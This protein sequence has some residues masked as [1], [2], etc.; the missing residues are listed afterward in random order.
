LKAVINRQDQIILIVNKKHNF[1]G[2]VLSVTILSAIFFASIPVSAFSQLNSTDSTNSTTA[3][4]GT[5]NATSNTNTNTNATAG[6]DTNSSSTG[7][8]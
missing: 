7:S 1:L 5:I 8:K 2:I 4:P 6:T 3:L